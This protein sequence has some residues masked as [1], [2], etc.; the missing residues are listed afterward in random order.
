M[1][2]LSGGVLRSCYRALSKLSGCL[3]GKCRVILRDLRSCRRS[4]VGIVG[5]CRAKHARNTPV[6]SLTLG[7]LR[8]V[9][10]GRRG[11]R[12]IVCFSA[13]MGKRPLGSAAVPIGKRG[14]EVVKLLYVGFCV[15]AAVTSFFYGFTIP[16]PSSSSNLAISNRVRRAFSRD[17]SSLLRRAV[18]AIH[19]RILVSSTVSDAGGGGRVVFQL[20]RRKVFGLGSTIVAVT[21]TLKVD[22]GAMCL[23][24]HGLRGAGGWYC[25]VY[26]LL[27]S[28]RRGKRDRF[29][30]A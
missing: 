6:A 25:I 10:Q 17:D 20:C 18:R 21:S 8:R 7:V 22:G 13:G 29:H 27:V 1:A 23:R 3:K 5:K 15:G 9:H 16:V 30:F 11:S 12:N 2:S 4:T 24:L 19:R 14:S 28:A 26:G